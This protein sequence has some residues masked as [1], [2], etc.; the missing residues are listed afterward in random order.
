MKLWLI[1]VA[2][3]GVGFAGCGLEPA[4][5][6]NNPFGMDAQQ[7]AVSLGATGNL[8][9]GGTAAEAGVVGTG[10]LVETFGDIASLPATP[11][12]FSFNLPLEAKVTVEGDV[13]PDTVVL[14]DVSLDLSL[15]DAAHANPVELSVP[16]D[17]TVTLTRQADGS[18]LAAST[19]N[20]D[21]AT[22]AFLSVVEPAVLPTVMD[23]LTQ[24]GEN[25][26]R[27]TVRF[28]ASDLLAGESVTVTFQG[29]K[30][31]VSF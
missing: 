3:L 20:P 23:L 27:A 31:T 7:V 18:Y 30:G 12:G 10:T 25:T 1:G 11:K 5:T 29:T 26:V 28:T 17:G 9:A 22:L 8:L 16:L 6:V 24:G 21:P 4:V 19:V 2:V 14:S 13:Q 15:S